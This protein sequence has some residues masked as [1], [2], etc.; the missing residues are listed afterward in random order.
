[1][2]AQQ[3]WYTGDVTNSAASLSAW[4][5]LSSLGSLT[6]E[7]VEGSTSGLGTAAAD[8]SEAKNSRIYIFDSLRVG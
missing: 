2:E 4:G 7:R 6:L 8:A 1:M 5:R 3:P